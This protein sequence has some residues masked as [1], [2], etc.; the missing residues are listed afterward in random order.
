MS[1]A[2][3]A[4]GAVVGSAFTDAIKN[5]LGDGNIVTEA[6]VNSVLNLTKKLA[7]S[8]KLANKGTVS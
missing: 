8:M 6:T 2:A 5:S 7:T 3:I 4:D 1:I